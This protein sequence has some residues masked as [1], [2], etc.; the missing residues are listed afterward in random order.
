MKSALH[1]VSETKRVSCIP[2]PTRDCQEFCTTLP[3]VSKVSGKPNR[4]TQVARTSTT[5]ELSQNTSTTKRMYKRADMITAKISNN[6][7]AAV[8]DKLNTIL[9]IFCVWLIMSRL[10]VTLGN[11]AIALTKPTNCKALLSLNLT[12]CLM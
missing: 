10:W 4:T 8:P 11:L 9:R 3:L 5:K 12:V 6:T 2:M 7:A 1:A